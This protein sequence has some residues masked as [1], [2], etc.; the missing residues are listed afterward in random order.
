MKRAVELV[1]R[2]EAVL[3]ILLHALE[4]DCLELRVNVG[5]DLAGGHGLLRDLLHG[6]GHGILAVERNAAGGG[7]VHHDAEGVE[8]GGGAEGLALCLLGRDVVRGAKHGVVGGEVAVLGACDAKVH[9][10][11][12]AV[13]LHHDVLRL[14]VAVDDVMVVGDGERLR[15]LRADLRD[16]LAVEGAVLADAALEVGPA[17]VL[18]DDVVGVAVL[19]PVVD[20][21]DVGAVEGSRRLRLLLEARCEGRVGRILGQHRLDGDG[22]PQDL[23]HAT[24]DRGHASRSHLVEDLVPSTKDPVCHLP[25]LSPKRQHRVLCLRLKCSAVRDRYKQL[26]T[27][28][29]RAS[30]ISLR[31]APGC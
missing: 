15:N 2:L 18:H 27:C 7:L 23:I 8:V 29:G 10:L 31:L 25:L 12:V 20:R 11:Y 5:V 16:L 21:D 3:G 14:D 30:L 13:R 19:A 28:E 24:V 17:Q 26:M 9:H 4:D 22:P 1:G 6:D